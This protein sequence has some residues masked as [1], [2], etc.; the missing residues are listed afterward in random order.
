MVTDRAVAVDDGPV[1]LVVDVAQD[2][3]LCRRAVRQQPKGLVAVAG[4][5]HM[6][7]SLLA[8]VL[9]AQADQPTTT[10]P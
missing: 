4:Q 9:V 3:G 2:I 8:L 1:G 10:P 6:V 5:D 7:K